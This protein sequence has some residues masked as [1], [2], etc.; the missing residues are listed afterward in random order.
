M[1]KSE[2]KLELV[3]KIIIASIGIAII[4]AILSTV[5][6]V[7]Y[8][9]KA[10]KDDIYIEIPGNNKYKYVNQSNIIYLYE[11]KNVSDTY[12]C[13]SECKI[14][15]YEEDQFRIEYDSFISIYDN[16]KYL[17]YN[18][19]IKAVYYTF[20]SYPTK[21]KNKNYG[22]VVRDTKYGIM[23]KTG[24][25]ILNTE[26]DYIET[27][28]NNIITLKNNIINIYD[29]T[30]KKLTNDEIIN[31]KEFVVLEEEKEKTLY[32]YTTYITGERNIITFDLIKNSYV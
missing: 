14:K 20:D 31:I 19:E 11:G 1:G 13:I 32:I 22:L 12:T 27:S 2:T 29:Y 23:N 4:I 7:N 15:D 6:W 8:K 24:G 9:S 25:L 16:N 21:T 26:Y 18:P 28:E 10:S 3:D 30:G 5:A 17:L